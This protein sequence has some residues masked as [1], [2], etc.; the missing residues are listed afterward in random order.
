MGVAT[1]LLLLMGVATH[2]LLAFFGVVG[3]HMRMELFLWVLFL[4]AHPLCVSP[5]SEDQVG[6]YD[7]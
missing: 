7:W 4:A 2:V 5:L 3:A 6:N 1:L